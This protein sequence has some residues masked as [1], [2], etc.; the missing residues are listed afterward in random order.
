MSKIFI[1]KTEIKTTIGVERERFIIDLCHKRIVPVIGT[2]LP[3]VQKIAKS[4]KVLSK[5]FG[6]ELFAGQI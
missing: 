2:L 4:R 6:Y 5:L 1:G 3:V